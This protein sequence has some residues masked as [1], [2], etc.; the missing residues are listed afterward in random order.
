ML[1]YDSEQRSFTYLYTDRRECLKVAQVG[2]KLVSSLPLPLAVKRP[3]HC[4]P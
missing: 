2:V 1:I 4:V 3:N